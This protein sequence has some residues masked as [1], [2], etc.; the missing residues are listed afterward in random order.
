MDFEHEGLQFMGNGLG[1]CGADLLK[2]AGDIVS[3]GII[4]G[5]TSNKIPLGK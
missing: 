1:A 5:Y 3:G 4:C 2:V